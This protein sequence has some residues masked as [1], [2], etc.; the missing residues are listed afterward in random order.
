MQVILSS[1]DSEEWTANWE[2]IT[3]LEGHHKIAELALSKTVNQADLLYSLHLTFP[4][5]MY[6][7]MSWIFTHWFLPAECALGW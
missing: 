3:K 7:C 2:H 5:Y 6:V 1:K 4:T